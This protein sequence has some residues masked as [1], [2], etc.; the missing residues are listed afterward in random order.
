MEDLETLNR[1]FADHGEALARAEEGIRGLA[2]Q[3][4]DRWYPRFHIASDGGWINDPNGLSHYAGRWHVFY[5]LHPFS[6]HWGPMHWGHVSSADLVTWR[7]EPVAL[8]PSIGAE[9]AGV[10]SGSA[11]TGDDGSLHV[12]YTG[13]QWANGVDEAEGNYEVQCLATSRDGVTFEKRGV[14]VP[15]PE[16]LRDFRDPKVWK[17]DGVW[18]MVF[19][20]R[21]ADNRGE[22]VRYTSPDGVAWTFSEVLFRHPDPQV[23]ML[24][25]PDFFPLIAPDGTRRWVLCLS[26]MGACKAGYLNRNGVNAGYLVGDWTPDGPFRPLTDFRP[27]DWGP[28]F[29]APQTMLAP[30]GRRLMLGW[31]RPEGAKTEAEDGWCGQMALPRE[32][33]LTDGGTLRCAPVRE[34][35]ALREDTRELGPL[36]LGRDE[37]LTLDPDVEAAEIELVIDLERTNAE[38]AGLKLHATEDGGYVYAAF[39]DQSGRIVVDRQASPLGERGYRSAPLDGAVSAGGALGLRVFVDRGS[40]EVFAGD[41]AQAISA[42][43]FPTA[44]PRAVRLVSEGGTLAVTELRIHRLRSIGLD[45]P[46]R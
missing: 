3:R 15:N 23:Y 39:D 22:I 4:R 10:F 42:Y 13:H 30:D 28:N 32:V 45:A 43:S 33:E 7:R 18:Q 44:G 46:A 19:G 14:V 5:Q 11:V 41:G 12:Y 2:A 16:R 8:A 40:I 35:A 6:T 17:L 36:T 27:W 1:P 31:M 20:R 21:S 38:R 37:E 29:Y 25:C 34:L 9:R 24:E 26:A